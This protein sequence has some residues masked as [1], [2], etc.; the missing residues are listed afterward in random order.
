[1]TLDDSILT[2]RRHVIRRAA[3]L[4]SV[5]INRTRFSWTPSRLNRRWWTKEGTD[6][7]QAWEANAD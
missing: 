3:E 5:S 2:W 6:G 4:G 7:R 1:M